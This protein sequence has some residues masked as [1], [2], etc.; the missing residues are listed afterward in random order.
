MMGRTSVL[1]LIGILY[2]SMFEFVHFALTTSTITVPDD[3]ST[4]QAAVNVAN[5]G[6]TIYVRSGNYSESVV[7]NK[8]LTLIGESPE[9]TLIKSTQENLAAVLITADNVILN[10]FTMHALT[11]FP[12]PMDYAPVLVVT[13]SYSNMSG[14]IIANG[15][16]AVG[17]GGSYNLFVNNTVIGAVLVGVSVWEASNSLIDGN[18]ISYN[19]GYGLTVDSSSNI[20]IVRN[21]IIENS[22]GIASF[23]V[24]NLG[25]RIFHNN[26]MNNSIRAEGSFDN[27]TQIALDD[28]YPSGGNYWSDC[29]GIDAFQGPNQK[30]GGEPGSDGFWDQGAVVGWVG[31]LGW[32]GEDH[33]P[34]TKPYP[35]ADHDLGV[36]FVGVV[37]PVAHYFYP[38]VYGPKVVVGQGFSQHLD[39]FVMNYGSSSEVFNLTVYADTSI[40]GEFSNVVLDARNSTILEFSW[41]TSGI[42]MGNYTVSALVDPVSGESDVSDNNYAIE[43]MISVPGDINGDTKVDMR[44]IGFVASK[45]SFLPSYTGWNPNHDIND[46]GKIDMFDIGTAARHFMEHYP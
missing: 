19:Y 11:P 5:P 3:Y 14:N 24:Y 42:E 8:T 6:D 12:N 28:G 20:T 18:V 36:S 13:G 35:W 4:I 30:Y 21:N 31:E 37:Y 22:R 38:F 29:A 45:F 39:V 44:D 34:F 46:D 2:L 1:L 40:I 32:A 33:F 7:L 16:I 17:L 9:S 15:R 26:L 10:G 25:V 23:D 27:T 41:N 43:Q